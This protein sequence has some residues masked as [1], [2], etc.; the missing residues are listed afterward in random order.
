M[1]CK[2]TG[3]GDLTSLPETVPAFAYPLPPFTSLAPRGDLA[4]GDAEALEVQVAAVLGHKESKA[5]DLGKLDMRRLR[6][7]NI[8]RADASR[9]GLGDHRQAGSRPLRPRGARSFFVGRRALLSAGRNVLVFRL[10][11]ATPRPKTHAGRLGHICVECGLDRPC[12]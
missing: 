11:R 4:F 1:V 12:G 2:R 5:N 6:R 7:T 3:L 10:H 8:G 9:R